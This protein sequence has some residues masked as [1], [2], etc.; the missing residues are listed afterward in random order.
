VSEDV[1]AGLSAGFRLL[2]PAAATAAAPVDALFTAMTVLCG[3]VAVVICLVIIAF[4]VRYRR[5]SRVPRGEPRRQ[6][7]A[8][9]VA[10]TLTPLAIFIG[11][12]VWAARDYMRLYAPPPDALP[13]VVVAKQWMWKLQHRNGRREINE[14]HVP[15][16]RP[17]L[18]KMTS[19][20]AIHSFY[21]PAFRLKQDV[22]P[23]RYTALWFTATQLG[24]FRLFCAEFCGTQH[25]R[26]TG[27]I[28]VMRPDDYA[29]WLAA[30]P[31]EPGLAQYGFALFRQLGCSGCHDTA[32]TVHAPLLQGLAGR[33]VHL[34]DGR[35]V[36]AD[37]NYLRD[38]IL[39]P[40][41]DVVAGFAPVMPS[42]AGQVSEEDL[43]A[44]IAYLHELA[45]K[46]PP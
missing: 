22:L 2:E 11:L 12:Y 34:Q 28:V 10:W 38:A 16:G 42:Y 9:E 15:L 36:V 23:G 30:G 27:R 46:A 25:S 21:V 18:L 4:A 7:R 26:M 31:A 5:G 24:E 45:A 39:T 6:M 41:K 14:L 8:L 13:V 37:D 17:V 43:H 19:Q 3:T 20:D 32:S 33:V 44:L 1:D 40:R 29:R 35:S